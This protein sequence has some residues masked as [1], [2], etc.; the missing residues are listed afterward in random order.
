MLSHKYASMSAKETLDDLSKNHGRVISKNYL[1]SISESVSNIV[2]SKSDDWAY[3]LPQA[4]EM[5]STILVSMDG[6]ML[7][8]CD[9][10]WREGMVGTISLYNDK[11][12]R[13]H[14]IYVGEAPEYGKGSF[15]D[16]MGIEIEKIKE[17][18]PDA[19]YLGIADGAKSN[20]SFLEKHTQRQLLDFLSRHGISSKGFFCRASRKDG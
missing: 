2:Q 11:S 14:T 12:Q 15:M 8:T 7:G 10:G 20:W 4:A 1:Q 13:Q 5:I 18:Y 16:R 19:L 17:H 6:A 3:A 9:N